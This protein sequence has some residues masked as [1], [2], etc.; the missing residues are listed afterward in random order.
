[1]KL[2]YITLE[3]INFL[4]FIISVTIKTIWS[5]F[6]KKGHI[7]SCTLATGSMDAFMVHQKYLKKDR[8]PGEANL[9]QYFSLLNTEVWY[10]V[11][12]HLSSPPFN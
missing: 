5:L 7:K 1:M 11:M 12:Q 10:K 3:S 2:I 8:S 6:I 9:Y 4:N